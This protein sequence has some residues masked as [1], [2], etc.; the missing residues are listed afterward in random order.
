M[1]KTPDQKHFI[2]PRPI[3]RLCTESSVTNL[4]AS[5]TV[6]GTGGGDRK[7]LKNFVTKQERINWMV[8]SKYVAGDPFK[9]WMR[10]SRRS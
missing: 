10:H 7:V 1:M 8:P 6:I 9:I 2:T 3:L 4:E 5:K